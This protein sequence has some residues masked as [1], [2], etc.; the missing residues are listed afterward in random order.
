MV[1]VAQD[2]FPV[3]DCVCCGVKTFEGTTGPCVVLSVPDGAG[4]LTRTH[5]LDGCC[6]SPTEIRQ[7]LGLEATQ[8]IR[9]ETGHIHEVQDYRPVT[10]PTQTVPAPVSYQPQY[11]PVIRTVPAFCAGSS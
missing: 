4:G 11:V 7:H 10:W 2:A 1:F 5:T 9:A 3:S 6:W 8:Q